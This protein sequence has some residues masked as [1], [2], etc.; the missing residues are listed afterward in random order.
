M[1]GSGQHIIVK[2][3]GEVLGSLTSSIRQTQ[4]QISSLSRNV[5][6]TMT[7]AASA[8][9]QGFKNVI[10]SD[11]YQAAAVAAAGVGFALRGAVTDAMQFESAMADVAKVVD[12]D[13][14]GMQALRG[15]ILNLSRE[16]PIAAEGFAQI[17]AAAGQA[18]IP[19]NELERFARSAARMGVAFDISAD[20]A[21]NAMAKLRTSMNLNQDQVEGLADSMNALSNSMASSAPEITNFMLRTGALTQQARVTPQQLAS[22]G[23]AMIAAGFEAEVAATSTRNLFRAL[24]QGSAAP[25]KTAEAF[26]EL[27][28]STTQVAQDMQRDAV[29][30]IKNV[31]DRLQAI[32]PA[33]RASLAQQI[34][35]SEARAL[36]AIMNN[37]ELLD[38]AL[39]TGTGDVSGSMQ[40]EFEARSQ[41]VENQMQI[42]SNNMK[43]LGI[44]V[45]SALLPGINGL[46]RA[47]T[48]LIGFLGKAAA[49]A[50][51]LTGIIAALGVAFV[52]VVAA[53]PFISA[54]ISVFGVLST[55]IASAG[56]AA[57]VLGSIFAVITGPIGLTIAAIVGIG[58]A[59]VLAYNKIGWFRDA[60]NGVVNGIKNIFLGLFNWLKGSFQ[61]LW[62]ILSGDANLIRAGFDNVVGG[63]KQAFGGLLGAMG[64]I[65]S[66]IGN[67]LLSIP[68]L[69][70]AAF[71]GL[72]GLIRNVFTGIVTLAGLVLQ[73]IGSAISGAFT[74]IVGAFQGIGSA[75]SGAIQGLVA[76]ITQIFGGVPQAILSILFPLPALAVGIFQQFGPAISGPIS[77]AVA[78]AQGLFNG[79]VSFLMSIPGRVAGMGAALVQTIIDGIQSKI[80]ELLSTV[81]GALSRVRELLPFSDARTGPLSTLTQSGASI[82]TTIAAG[83]QSVGDGGLA[84]AVS[85]GLQSVLGALPGFAQQALAGAASFLAPTPM[86]APAAAPVAT[87]T[88]GSASSTITANFTINAPT[89]NGDAIAEKVKEIFADL[90]ADAQAGQ[91]AYLND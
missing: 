4:T 55:A 80:G 59:L 8:G 49:A 83:V 51:P 24:Q 31:F 30:T 58:A 21:G 84:Q 1:A 47:I 88:A 38:R 3:G 27:G 26:A 48:P 60:V 16:I 61:V 73:G 67:A 50:G 68:K 37:R 6:R 44:E 53:L 65:L 5:S 36:G 52:G 14:A 32:D 28:L 7:D 18:G 79:F 82:L 45:G 57:A 90:L 40:R 78:T 62:G 85:G 71:M 33:Q 34:F 87:A 12:T 9:A 29:G 81:S 25:R 17:V 69:I 72:L 77:G 75:I 54:G 56:G 76:T 20:E 11:A 39:A 13:A 2:I 22:M 91:R 41:T 64:A 42:F 19:A 66:G 63:I 74:A 35:G 46:L 43:A 70:G 89:G 10:R 15:N 86:G 23:S